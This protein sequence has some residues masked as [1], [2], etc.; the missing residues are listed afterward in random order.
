MENKYENWKQT[1]LK[2]WA[3]SNFL[4]LPE[5]QLKNIE[6]HLRD[7]STHNNIKDGERN[8]KNY[9]KDHEEA[10][11]SEYV[12]LVSYGWLIPTEFTVVE[13]KT[14]KIIEHHAA[15]QTPMEEWRE[16]ALELNGKYSRPTFYCD[17]SEPDRNRILGQAGIAIKTEKCTRIEEERR[18]LMRIHW[19]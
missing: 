4:N 10:P 5:E 8:W 17:S 1:P 11:Q 19:Q 3:A 7:L 16:L 2:D 12:V 15:V 6:K 14:N 18:R 13:R 9:L